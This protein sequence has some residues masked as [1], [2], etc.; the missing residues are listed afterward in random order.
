[1]S[2]KQFLSFEDETTLDEEL[3]VETPAETIAPEEV[4]TY[5]TVDEVQTEL[6][7]QTSGV[8][9]YDGFVEDVEALDQDREIIEERMEDPEYEGMDEVA[10]EMFKARI[11]RFGEK[12]G[13]KTDRLSNIFSVEN[14][15]GTSKQKRR[16]LTRISLEDAEKSSDGFWS[17]VWAGA[18]AIW[19]AIRNFFGNFFGSLTTLEDTIKKVI[20]KVGSVKGEPKSD[21]LKASGFAKMFPSTDKVLK[22][23]TILKYFERQK[24]AVKE[25]ET[26][27]KDFRSGTNALIDTLKSGKKEEN[28][29]DVERTFGTDSEPL[30]NGKYGTVKPETKEGSKV[31]IVLEIKTA[32]IKVPDEVKLEP[33]DKD[34][35]IDILKA[36]LGLIE[37]SKSI[38]K[39]VDEA[40]KAFKQA[41]KL[42]KELIGKTEGEAKTKAKESMK[43]FTK[44][45]SS[46]A[47]VGNKCNSLV[48]DTSMTGIKSTIKLTK[49]YLSAFGE[50]KKGEENKDGTTEAEYT[51]AK[52]EPSNEEFRPRFGKRPLFG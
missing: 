25:A 26:F 49:V 17:K 45:V 14:F 9:H 48:L 24:E 32:E 40:D 43:S 10:I 51:E 15:E 16:E 33:A 36:G 42:A 44:G 31:K 19:E 5:E 37:S 2:L 11:T 52:E 3:V 7:E 13:V 35:I 18:V 22:V 6:S 38:K 41:M 28:P 47:S 23:E 30:I 20:K 8:D 39:T 34:K 12:Y 21:D 27:Y 4:E 50:T 1:M 46:L 29:I